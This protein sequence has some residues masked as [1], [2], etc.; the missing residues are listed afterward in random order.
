MRTSFLFVLCTLSLIA[1]GFFMFYV[2]VC[3][4]V[5]YLNPVGEAVDAFLIFG[6]LGC[7]IAICSF[8][9]YFRRLVGSS[10]NLRSPLVLL[11]A[12]LGAGCIYEAIRIPEGFK[13]IGL[14]L[15]LT[16]LS[17]SVFRAMKY[18]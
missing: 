17:L 10:S 8:C 14:G 11:I 18:K 12:C 7:V 6:L 16:F 9:F 2:G 1:A 15:V 4:S 5:I 3:F 13:L